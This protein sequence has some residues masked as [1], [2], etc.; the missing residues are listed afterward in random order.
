MLLF[1]LGSKV[2][3]DEEDLT[4]NVREALK[5]DGEAT[6]SSKTTDSTNS[7]TNNDV[8]GKENQNQTSTDSTTEQQNANTKDADDES[9]KKRDK[10]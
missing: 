2:C 5:R 8:D 9:M 6:N 1:I 3:Y 7:N 10:V 4:K